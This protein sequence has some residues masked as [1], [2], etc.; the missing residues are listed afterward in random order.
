MSATIQHARRHDNLPRQSQSEQCDLG[1]KELRL[2]KKRGN[3][4]EKINNDL[5]EDNMVVPRTEISDKLASGS[6][7][8]LPPK[9]HLCMG[10]S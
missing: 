8:T 9:A 4:S 6:L 5:K 7:G 10:K 2:N 1:I 3:Q